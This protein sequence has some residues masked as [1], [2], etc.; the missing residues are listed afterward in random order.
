[1][2]KFTRIV[3]AMALGLSFA[4]GTLADDTDIYLSPNV[5][6]GAEPLVMFVLDYRSNLG[7]TAC[8][9]SECDELIAQGANQLRGI[10]FVVAESDLLTDEA[11]RRAMADAL[12]KA[13]L[14]AEEASVIL[15]PVIGIEER[16]AAT[17][18]PRAFQ[19]SSAMA[20]E[21]MP[22]APGEQEFRVEVLVRYAIE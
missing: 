6:A 16:A 4:D 13:L 2:R 21:A 14:Y 20:A 5:A 12:R 11:R 22:V 3:A 8:N 18:M 17:P 19:A 7:S 1:M 9:G 10:S 15:G